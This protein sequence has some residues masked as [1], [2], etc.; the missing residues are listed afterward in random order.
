MGGAR[1]AFVE[2]HRD[3][4]ISAQ[5]VMTFGDEAKIRR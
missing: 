3:E 4:R 5:P 2:S 1:L